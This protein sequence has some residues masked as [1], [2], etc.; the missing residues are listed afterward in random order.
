MKLTP[1][2]ALLALASPVLAQTS[3]T[4]HHASTTAHRTASSS[5][6]RESDIPPLGTAIPKVAG[7]PKTL[8][9]LKYIDTVVGTGPLA[10]P[11]K[12]YT[13]NYTGYLTNGTKF[14]SSVDRKDPIIFPAGF[15]RVIT[16][17]DTGFQG[18]HV[19]GKRRLFIPYELAYGE[20]GKPPTIPEKS[21]LV[22]DVELIA[23][24]DLPQ[25]PPQQPGQRPGAPPQPR[26]AT[27][28]AGTTPPPAPG[29]PAPST[30]PKPLADPTK[31]ATVPPPTDPTKP[32]AVPPKPSSPSSQTTS[33]Q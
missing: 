19:G 21:M 10:V 17:W 12:L 31:P 33:K 28:P 9:A 14:D 4:A 11:M 24:A 1:A 20:A 22:F 27:P 23:Q 29:L 2:L 3:S 8:Y 30:A 6:C 7:C 18:M 13:V 32:T 25:Q 16:G 15:H 5:A 26:P